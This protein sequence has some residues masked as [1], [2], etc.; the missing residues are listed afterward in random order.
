LITWR[1]AA[2][3]WRQRLNTSAAAGVMR[4]RAER[5]DERRVVRQV[6]PAPQLDLR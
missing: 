6:G 3:G 1:D 2:L 5:V 4:C